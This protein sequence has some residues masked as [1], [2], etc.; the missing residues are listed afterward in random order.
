MRQIKNA[1]LIKVSE[2]AKASGTSV[3]TIHHYAREGLLTPPTK[4]SRNM[5]YYDRRSIEEIRL[6]QE[7]QLKR[8]LPLVTIKLILQAKREGQDINHIAEMQNLLEGIFQPIESETQT[9][10]I[11]LVEMIAA[12]GLSESTLKALENTG[13]IAPAPTE[14]GLTFDDIDLRIARIFKKLADY[15]LK[16][17]DFYI[18]RTYIEIIRLEAK[19]M[20]D[21]M[22]RLP[23]HEKV[24]LM[25]I[26]KTVNE[27]KRY[28][29]MRIYRQE[30][31]RDY[32]TETR[33]GA[34]K[35]KFSL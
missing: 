13:L 33:Q 11:T 15:G 6:I 12:T 35:W 1:D 9:R 23:D 5:A 19:Q 21:M 26:F 20:H 14:K 4:T 32:G 25:D 18:Y 34:L 29:A 28:M 31:Q 27:L 30:V 17:E 22:H 24:P 10:N 8:F 2:L 16:P 7:L 3:S